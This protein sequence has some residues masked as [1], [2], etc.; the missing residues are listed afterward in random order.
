M[1]KVASPSILSQGGEM[2]KCV[3]KLMF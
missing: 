1:V 2:L 3:S